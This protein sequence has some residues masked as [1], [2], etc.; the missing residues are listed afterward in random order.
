VTTY[1]SGRTIREAL[2]Q[3]ANGATWADK[4]R[5]TYGYGSTTISRVS[6]D[7]IQAAQQKAAQKFLSMKG[8]RQITDFHGFAFNVLGRQCTGNAVAPTASSFV[9]VKNKVQ[10]QR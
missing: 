5:T 4:D 10:G 6:V 7:R 1:N 9:I 3:T 8:N 2:N